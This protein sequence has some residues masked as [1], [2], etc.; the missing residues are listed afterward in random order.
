MSGVLEQILLRSDTQDNWV[1]VNPV[2]GQGEAG[3][4]YDTNRFKIGN[5]T[6]A[7]NSLSYAGGA[8]AYQVNGTV[9][10][11]VQITT[12]GGITP[13]NVQREY[14]LIKG[15]GGPVVIVATPPIAA[16]TTIGQELLLEGTDDT[17]TVTI[18]PGAGVSLNGPII[19]GL[20]GP[21]S[22]LLLVWNGNTWKEVSRT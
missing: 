3:F 2:L 1:S 10:V 6:L 7:Y 22:C 4:E 16:G 8:G 14:Q 18:D 15:A 11:P 19:M 12:I 17:N 13:L 9:S 21:G 5:G 20:T